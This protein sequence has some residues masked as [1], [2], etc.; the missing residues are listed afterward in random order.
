[1][2]LKKFIISFAFVTALFSLSVYAKTMEFT[3]GSCEVNIKEGTKIISETIETAPYTVNDRTMV[4]VRIISENFNAN[5]LWDEVE[6]KVTVTQVD[7]VIVFVLGSDTAYVNGEPVQLDAAANELNGRTMIPLRF[8]SEN[9]NYDVTYVDATEQVLITDYPVIATVNGHKIS[10][11]S[12]EFL[13]NVFKDTAKQTNTVDKAVDYTLNALYE[14]YSLYDDAVNSGFGFSAEDYALIKEQVEADAEDIPETCLK[15]I[16]ADYLTKYYMNSNIMNH[17]LQMGISE[18]FDEE[19]IG[20]YYRDNYLAAKHILIRSDSGNAE[21]AIKDIESKLNRGTDFDKLMNEYSEDPGLDSN[22]DGYVFTYGEMVPEFEKTV[23]ELS[24]DEISGIVKTDNGY[25][26][27]KRIELPEPDDTILANV[28]NTMIGEIISD[29][30][31]RILDES[32]C[33]ANF[34]NAEIV[35]MFR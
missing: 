9:L 18:D 3:M 21:K 10:Y 14:L 20:Q 32:E 25:H 13:Y 11:D 26:I 15:S 17:V 5:V 35:E 30:T 1:M 22:P 33:I 34:S 2:N 31:Q 8:V 16:Y 6:Q 24:V 19:S 4:P 29:Y 23:T 27:I 28:M 7:N 12:F